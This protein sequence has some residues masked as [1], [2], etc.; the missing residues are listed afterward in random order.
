M[1]FP[2]PT[3]LLQSRHLSWLTAALGLAVLAGAVALTA[4]QTRQSIR[5]QITGRDG[6]ILQAVAHMHLNQA[7]TDSLGAP[8]DSATLLT[9]A[10]QASRLKDVLGV[11]VFDAQARMLDAFPADLLEGALSPGDL[12]ALARGQ[13]VSRFHPAFVVGEI[14]LENGDP[15]AR[16][17][18]LEV[19]VPLHPGA[20]GPLAGVVQFLVDG[21]SVSRE[22]ARLDGNLFL[23]AAVTFLAGG[24]ILVAAIAGAF[25]RLQR[26]HRLLAERTERLIEANR[27]LA[28][29]ARTSAVGAVASHLI[30]GLRNP[31]AGLQN[32][33]RSLAAAPAQGT[34]ADWEQAV[35]STRRMQAMIHEVIAVLRDEQSGVRYEMP[36]EE[37]AAAVE[38]KIQPL[39]RERR[40][41]LAVRIETP[42][43][44]PHRVANLG[45]LILGNLAQNAVEASPRGGQVA[46]RV[47]EDE[48]G[49]VCEVR[50][51]GP[52]FPAGRA[53]FAPGLS[54]KEGGSGIGLAICKQLAGHLGAGLELRENSPRGC[55]FALILPTTLWRPHTAATGTVTL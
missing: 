11:R 35:A 46:F 31:L 43:E 13:P 38:R 50:D 42:A 12:P 29:A 25:R 33:V 28:L 27:E 48:Q 17:P 53:V 40:V 44:L 39:C 16:D 41:A 51:G 34:A 14:F 47:F 2:S 24:L 55:V 6:A 3:R 49:L 7:V 21:D 45:A 15:D 30:H 22:F 8:E 36:V 54:G 37:L 9:V 1:P 52:G 5:E 4:L 26:T 20:D 10:L 32:Y 18:L 19:N 23:Q